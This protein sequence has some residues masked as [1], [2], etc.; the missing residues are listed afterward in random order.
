MA[1]LPQNPEA[2]KKQIAIYTAATTGNMYVVPTGK[3]FV[4]YITGNSGASPA[5]NGVSMPV[6]TSSPPVQIEL[7]AGTIVSQS[8]PSY[9]F[10]IFG[11]E[12]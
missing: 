7:V 6:I 1:L 4:G 10:Y 2:T 11:V 12:Q 9:P 3:K 5:I 8:N